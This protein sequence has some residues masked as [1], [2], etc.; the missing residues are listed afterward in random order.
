MSDQQYVETDLHQT[1]ANLI[2]LALARRTC[3]G[4]TGSV[5]WHNSNLGYTGQTHVEVLLLIAAGVVKAGVGLAVIVVVVVIVLPAVVVVVVVVI[6]AVVIVPAVVVVV[7]AAAA[8]VGGGVTV[9]VVATTATA[10][11]AVAMVVMIL[12]RLL[13]LGP[14]KLRLLQVL[15]IEDHMTFSKSIRLRSIETVNMSAGLGT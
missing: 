13:A 6:V 2:A 14:D 10:G 7:T 4:P 11:I 15:L 1:I 12:D 8:T 5:N 3:V 9:H